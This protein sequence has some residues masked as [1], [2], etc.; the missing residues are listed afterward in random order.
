M[1]VVTSSILCSS[2]SAFCD[3]LYA[4]EV[5]ALLP[6]PEPPTPEEA[7]EGVAEVLTVLRPVT[8]GDGDGAGEGACAVELIL[9]AAIV[10][11]LQ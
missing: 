8:A 2:I 3:C 4:T 1:T 6:T 11:N 7:L 5:E 9:R 10:L